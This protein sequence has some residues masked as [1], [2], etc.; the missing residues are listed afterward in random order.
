[1]TN[2]ST[3]SERSGGR[4]WILF[5]CAVIAVGGF[6]LYSRFNMGYLGFP[7][8]DAWIH[9]TYARNL[10]QLGEWSYVPGQVSGG[11]TS[12]LWSVLLAAAYWLR[13]NPLVYTQ[14]LGVMVL[15]GIAWVGQHWLE[16][17]SESDTQR[18]FPHTGVFLIFE[19]HL[20]W[21]V[22]S[23]M[24]TG[25]YA[26]I[27][28]LVM[29]MI[30]QSEPKWVWIGGLIGLVVWI[31][32][33]GMTLL[34]PALFVGFL[35]GTDRK[36][37]LDPVWKIAAGFLAFVGP[38]LVFN[39]LVTGTVFPNTFY[40]K[41]A[42]Y[43]E[44]LQI[45][46]LKRILN[47]YSLPLVGAGILVLPGFVQVIYR[48]VRTKNWSIIGAGLWLGGYIL[49]YVLRL[50]VTYQHGRYIIPAM[51]VY[52]V[53]GLAGSIWLIQKGLESRKIPRTLCI[54][55]AFSI[56][57]VL[58]VFYLQGA[59]AYS[60]DVAFIEEEMV[61][62]AEWI[63]DHTEQDAFIAA[64]DIGALGYY[65]DRNI[66]DL[67]G[68]ISPEVIPFIRN[69]DELMAFLDKMKV[70]YLMTLPGWYPEMIQSG[71]L[72][73]QSQGEASPAM[74]GENMAVYRWGGAE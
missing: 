41:Q 54:G 30:I 14:I 53:L 3:R 69:E 74:G 50:P 26:L 29:A 20:I 44:M 27:I 24:E 18:R 59:A 12:P 57:A 60:R 40:A 2:P 36:S 10:A 37:R 33:D 25:L 7:L 47:L 67:A 65:G 31:R 11:S 9:Q 8:D 46:F 55:W 62:T 39:Y 21:A 5:L 73:Y 63:R 16:T 34:G 6:L 42:E 56:A 58:G 52:Y 38:Y 48:S 23:G 68:L 22:C 70:D 72:V 13:L 15:T 17:L 35:T 32:P 28:L 43:A 49:I 45:P 61:Q 66:L 51:P 71:D 4:F 64:H 19:W 1:M